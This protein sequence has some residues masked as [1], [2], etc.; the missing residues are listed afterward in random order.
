ME[1]QKSYCPDSNLVW[2]ILCTVFCCL[3]FGVVAIVK[4]S[5]VEKLWVQG[6]HEEAQKASDDAKKYSIWGAVCAGVFVILY[7][8][9]I[10]VVGLGA[11]GL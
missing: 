7:F 11:A 6:R 3:P 8:L 1:E 10:V 4:A 5:S 9:F 2:A